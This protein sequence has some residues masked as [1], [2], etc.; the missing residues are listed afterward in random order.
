[1]R[2]QVLPLL[3]QTIDWYRHTQQEQHLATGPSDLAFLADNRRIADQVVVL[4]FE[5]ARQEEQRLAKQSKANQALNPSGALSEYESLVQTSAET[6]QLVQ[7][8]QNEV[9]SLKQGVE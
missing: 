8:T 1:V 5:F 2:S 4:A 7:Q 6:D 3:T 9:E